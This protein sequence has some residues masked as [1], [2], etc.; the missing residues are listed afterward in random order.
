MQNIDILQLITKII[1]D[2][3]WPKLVKLMINKVNL[4]A[5]KNCLEEIELCQQLL[6]YL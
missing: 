2:I 5:Q 4:P 6:E 3:V 1:I